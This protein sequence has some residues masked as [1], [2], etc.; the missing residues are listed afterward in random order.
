MVQIIHNLIFVSS[1]PDYNLYIPHGSDNTELWI[2]ALV[3][4][5]NFIS[6]MV[7]IILETEEIKKT[8]NINFISHM[9]QIIRHVP[10][11]D[12]LSAYILYIPHGSDNTQEV[13]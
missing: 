7:Q 8:V 2:E 12:F 3:K 5:K 13:F 11:K 4:D 1:F 6:H 10:T 9:V